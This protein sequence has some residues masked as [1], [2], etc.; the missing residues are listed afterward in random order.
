[1]GDTPESGASCELPRPA[2]ARAAMEPCPTCGWTGPLIWVHGHG[3][4]PRCGTVIAP[5]CEGSPL[6]EEVPQ[7]PLSGD[8]ESQ[9]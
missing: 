8:T 3:Q 2:E 4:C 7:I 5:C 6:G 1:M 9:E